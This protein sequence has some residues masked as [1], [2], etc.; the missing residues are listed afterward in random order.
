MQRLREIRGRG[1]DRVVIVP[2]GAAVRRV[3]PARAQGR[4]GRVGAGAG[5]GG[6]RGARVG[7]E[8]ELA[9][10]A[11]GCGEGVACGELRFMECD[12]VTG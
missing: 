5:G 8:E 10:E 1:D 12:A 3:A 9:L 2:R 4:R 11:A 7:L 6:L